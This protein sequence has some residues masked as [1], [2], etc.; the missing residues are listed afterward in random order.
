MQRQYETVLLLARKRHERAV[1][2]TPIL[3]ALRAYVWHG[4]EVSSRACWGDACMI[5]W[6]RSRA[7]HML[8]SLL[9]ART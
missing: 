8:Q 3:V 1:P 2:G 5:S 6:V 4:Q 9:E 7:M